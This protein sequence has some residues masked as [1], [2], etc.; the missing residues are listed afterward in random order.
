MSDSA[1]LVSESCQLWVIEQWWEGAGFCLHSRSN[2]LSSLLKVVFYKGK[3]HCLLP[4]SFPPSLLFLSSYKVQAKSACFSPLFCPLLSFLPSS[5]QCEV[6]TS[7]SV[8][9]SPCLLH[10]SSGTPSSPYSFSL[11]ALGT[12]WVSSFQIPILPKE[13]ALGVKTHVQYYKL[14]ID[15]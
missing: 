14:V 4:P 8:I 12:K 7:F 1:P 11:S 13:F 10:T 3:L 6:I 9:L 15:I 5:A 2:I